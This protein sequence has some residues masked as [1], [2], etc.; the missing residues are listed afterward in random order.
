M[1]RIECMTDHSKTWNDLDNLMLP[2]IEGYFNRKTI[3][4][5][6]C[7]LEYYLFT[8]ALVCNIDD[9]RL[10]YERRYCYPNLESALTG[11][12][13]WDGNDHPP[14]NW[15]KCKGRY[16]GKHVDLINPNI[17]ESSNFKE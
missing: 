1:V 17:D 12:E 14:G 2:P 4:G 10:E 8:V 3:N 7:A 16:N 5:Q 9:E 6:H 15:I 13:R 11:L